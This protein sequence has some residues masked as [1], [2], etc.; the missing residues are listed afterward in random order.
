MI[1]SIFKNNNQLAFIVLPL[2]VLTVWLLSIF[3]FG[4]N[5]IEFES[6]I[7]LPLLIPKTI[8]SILAKGLFLILLI[9]IALLANWFYNAQEVGNEKQN[10]FS[11]LLLVLTLAPIAQQSILHPL[12][13][14]MC[15]T[16][17]ALNRL[18]SIY[19]SDKNV[20]NI[21]DVGFLFSLSC[22]IYVPFIVFL[23]LLFFALL[24][25]RSFNMREWIL[26]L[27]G[28]FTPIFIMASLFYLFNIG[29]VYWIEKLFESLKGKRPHVFYNGTFLLNAM[30]FI[31]A[32]LVLLNLI[33]G[34]SSGKVK[35]GKT[36][37]FL[38]AFLL[39]SIGLFF[40]SY[41]S[42][43]ILFPFALIPLSMLGS[44][45]LDGIKRTFI[46]DLFLLLLFTCLI[47]GSL[48]MT[49]VL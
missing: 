35:T 44:Y 2:I 19:R 27:L 14:V 10:Y 34:K 32:V 49:G 42:S 7:I 38:F 41:N 28:F 11:G 18:F 47:C 23:P 8:S 37:S 3:A 6:S 36:H 15:L 12:F 39:F 40:I 43:V 25:L 1:S 29:E 20:K 26:A 22:L 48:Q 46:V 13:F 5:K 45:I 4:C 16:L 30:Y 33:I 21:F 24:Q 31:L 9:S 17:L